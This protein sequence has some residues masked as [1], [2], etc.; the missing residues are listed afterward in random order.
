MGESY[1]SL[2]NKGTYNSDHTFYYFL[3]WKET[4]YFMIWCSQTLF[5]QTRIW[6]KLDVLFMEYGQTKAAR[7]YTN[8]SFWPKQYLLFFR[9]L[10]RWCESIFFGR[11]NT[12]LHKRLD[13]GKLFHRS[14]WFPYCRKSCHMVEWRVPSMEDSSLVTCKRWWKQRFRIFVKFTRKAISIYKLPSLWSPQT[15]RCLQRFVK[16]RFPD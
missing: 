4:R 9:Y 3:T 7:I 2:S 5:Q 13:F 14:A 15:A 1:S 16:T 6:S 8:R 10:D 11:Y 12:F